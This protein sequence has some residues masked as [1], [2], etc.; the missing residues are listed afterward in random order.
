M[1]DKYTLS[2]SC[3]TVSILKISEIGINV[4]ILTIR[5]IFRV[6]WIKRRT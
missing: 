6:F 2:N 5:S 4:F 1:L 3:Y